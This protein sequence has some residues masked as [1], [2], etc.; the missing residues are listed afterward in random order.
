MRCKQGD[1]AFVVRSVAGNEGKVVR[2]ATWI[3]AVLFDDGV[4]YDVWGV[5]GLGNVP[6]SRRAEFFGCDGAIS[7]CWLH[8][9]RGEPEAETVEDVLELARTAPEEV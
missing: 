8:P 7:D 4:A 5:D 6:V 1:L 9:I 2:C 3:G